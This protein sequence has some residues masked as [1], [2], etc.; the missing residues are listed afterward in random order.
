M[1][2]SLTVNQVINDTNPIWFYCGIPNHC[3]KGMFGGINI[4]QPDPTG[5]STDFMPLSSV[6]ANLTM[7]VGVEAIEIVL[8]LIIS[9]GR[10]LKWAHC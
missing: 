4:G 5:S 6:M 8:R 3:Q 9:L 10:T 7:M 1:V 2:F